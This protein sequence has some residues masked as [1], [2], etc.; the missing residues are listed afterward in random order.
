MSVFMLMEIIPFIVVF[1]F[2][3]VIIIVSAKHSKNS[4]KIQ[5]RAENIF[6]SILSNNVFNTKG[7]EKEEESVCEYCGTVVSSDK[8]KCPNC[9]ANITKKKRQ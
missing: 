6:D 3:V 4:T 5:D 2:I 8:K 7:Q 9:S 1:I